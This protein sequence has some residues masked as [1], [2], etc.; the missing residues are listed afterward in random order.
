TLTVTQTDVAGNVSVESAGLTITVDTAPPGHPTIDSVVDNL[1]VPIADGA[2][3]GGLTPTLSG[4]AEPDSIITIFNA[5][6]S[7][8]LGTAAT[9][10]DGNWTFTPAALP[11]GE[12]DIIT[13]A[14][15]AAGNASDPS[16]LYT[17][18]VVAD[19]EPPGSPT[20]DLIVNDFAAPVANGTSTNDQT[21]TL[22][23]T[24][25]P[26]TLITIYNQVDMSPLGTTLTDVDGNW[27]FT[28]ASDLSFTPGGDVNG[29]YDFVATATDAAGNIGDLTSIP[30]TIFIQDNPVCFLAGTL[31]ATAA[32]ERPIESLAIGEMVTL[33]DGTQKPI[34]W[35]GRMTVNLNRFN[36]HSASPILI[37]AGALGGGLPKR[38]LFTSYRHGFAV[39]GVLVIAGLLVN[40]TSIVQCSDWKESTVTFY[41]VEVEGH[42]LMLA[43][44]AAAETFGE[45]G[46][47][48]EL[49]DNAAEFHAMYPDAVAAEPMSMGRVISSRQI[50]RA[51]KAKIE[52]A[53]VEM[54]YVTWAAAA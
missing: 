17:F 14:S 24:A 9:D 51:V 36:R 40:G 20:I 15:D 27:T 28:P 52:T 42:E 4:T 26:G 33:A 34:K 41:Q 5:V 6:D 39:N 3:T 23:G 29:E 43:E 37:R 13:F 21:P 53:A 46:D 1:G 48:R 54:G 44:G 45:D 22:S 18:F 7:S 49:F 32:G 11:I 16:A 35:L 47:N 25:E 19:T 8:L 31:I 30:Y 50:P 38:D 10:V 12:Y 2:N